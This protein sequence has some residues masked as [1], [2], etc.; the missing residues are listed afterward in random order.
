MDADDYFKKEKLKIINKRFENEK[1]LNLLCNLPQIL[2][3]NFV[4]KKKIQFGL[5]FFLL[6]ALLYQEVHLKSFSNM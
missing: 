2:N 1:N 5:Q 6:V 3:K 4:F